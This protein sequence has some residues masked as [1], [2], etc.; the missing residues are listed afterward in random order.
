MAMRK[1]TR[2]QLKAIRRRRLAL[3]L[4]GAMAMPA[5]PALAQSL[6]DTGSVTSGTATITQPTASSMVIDQSSHGAIIDWNSF[7]IGSG[8]G[9]TFNVPDATGVTLNRVVGFGYSP[10]NI[11]GALTSNGQLFLI[12]PAGIVFNGTATVNVAGLVAST[13]DISDADFLAGLTSGQFRFATTDTS[14]GMIINDGQLA[15]ASGGTIALIGSRIENSGTITANQGSVVVGATQD[16]TLDFFGD[17]LTQVTVAGNGMGVSNCLSSVC[18]GGITSTGNI[19]ALGGNIELRTT[20]MDGA[21]AGTALFVDPANGGRIWIAGN[22]SAQTDGTRRGKVT[23]DAGLGNVDL[24]GVDGKTG[25][26]SAVGNDPGEQ[27]GTI[28]IRGNQLFTHLCYGTGPTDLCVA[29]N[30]LGLVN[31]SAYGTGGAGGEIH[32][33]VGRL[34]HGGLLQ[35][36]GNDG[37]GGLIDIKATN[38]EIYNW[39]FAYGNNGAGGTID[40]D[41]DSLLLFRG[42][43]AWLGGPG[44]AFWSASLLAYG[45]TTGGAVNIDAGDFTITDL[46]NTTPESADLVPII[47]VTGQ[48]GGSGGTI[49]ITAD[50]FNLPAGSLFDASGTH[51]GGSI[52]IHAGTLTLAGGLL[53]TGGDGA[54]GDVTTSASGDLVIAGTAYVGGDTWLLEAP[55]LALLAATDIASG[56]GSRVADSAISAALDRGTS[57]DI[58]ADASLAAGATGHIRVGNGAAITHT[59]PHQRSTAAFRTFTRQNPGAKQAP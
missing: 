51:D 41:A 48:I 10:S 4:L 15:A 59:D 56:S 53:A 43:Q 25:N 38:A 46:G 17:G 8:Y 18:V 55:D 36:V 34:Y 44:T 23:L 52:D 28:T 14:T 6:P 13:I 40:I 20:T 7:N 37:A 33:D 19:F 39:V 45:T 1:A 57:V 49:G 50:S 21:S 26:V 58:V 47:N 11:Y 30:R 2:K 16:V 35:A 12:N 29:N 31:A 24:G 32:I 42:Q 5:A 27:A 3:A 22:V 9:V 54:D